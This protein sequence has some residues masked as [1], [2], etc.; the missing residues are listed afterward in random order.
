MG[1]DV[2]VTRGDWWEDDGERIADQEWRDLVDRDPDLTMTG[3]VSVETPTGETL[4][5]RSEL[6]ALW[7]GHPE[8]GPI[9]FDFRDGRI[10]VKNPD[11]ATMAKLIEIAPTLG[12]QVQ[13]DEGETYPEPSTPKADPTEDVDAK[14]S[15]LLGRW[16]RGRRRDR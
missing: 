7:T 9:P 2:H 13:G 10:V 15:G 14:R 12:A 16:T 1:Y 11:D 4:T 8:D 3:E 6:L 5:Y